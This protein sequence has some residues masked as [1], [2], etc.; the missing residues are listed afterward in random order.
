MKNIQIIDGA[1]NCVYDIF[2]CEDS[3]FNVLFPAGTNVAFAD[4]IWAREDQSLLGRIFD[5]L[6]QRPVRKNEVA[7]IHG[8]I[9]YGLSEKKAYYPDR[10]DEGAINP[11]GSFLRQQS[12][13]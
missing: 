5:E 9:F 12:L 4:E 13:K 2:S 10:T 7:G 6:W 11:D 3:A 1:E 8:I